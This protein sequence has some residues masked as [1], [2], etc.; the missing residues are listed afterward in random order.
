M[1]QIKNSRIKNIKDFPID[2]SCTNCSNILNLDGSQLC[3]SCEEQFCATCSFSNKKNNICSNCQNKFE[4]H[5]IPKSISAILKKLL[6]KCTHQG[7]EKYSLYEELNNHEENCEFYL[8]ECENCKKD[9]SKLD[10][11]NHKISCLFFDSKNTLNE[12][13]NIMK[14]LNSYQKESENKFKEMSFTI[15]KL[16]KENESLKGE[17]TSL[18]EKVNT[19]TN[20]IDNINNNTLEPNFSSLHIN[21]IPSNNNPPNINDLIDLKL[22]QLEM[23]FSSLY[24]DLR[25]HFNIYT[26]ENET[27]LVRL[28]DDLAITKEKISDNKEYIF[29]NKEPQKP[30]ILFPN[31]STQLVTAT[32]NKFKTMSSSFP[33]PDNCQINIKCTKLAHNGHMVLGFSNKVL[34]EDRGYLGGDMGTGN[35]GIA[36]NGSLGEEGKW[37]K[38]AAYIEGD[39]V[40]LIKSGN[41]ISYKINNRPNDYKYI[42]T[43]KE[44]Y[45]ALTCYYEGEILDIIDY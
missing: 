11:K 21:E 25:I 45:L 17:I 38:G 40:S 24:E 13:E 32:K 35:W 31:N 20:K 37:K 33:L 22:E 12:N 44:L 7:C 4:S 43:G 23:K 26:Q 15:E 27:K 36:G 9:I 41:L 18:K 1:R 30:K 3:S 6:I 34:N 14:L 5:N 19:T 16:K 10:L 42:L 28:I 2:L 8:M 29:C 39:V